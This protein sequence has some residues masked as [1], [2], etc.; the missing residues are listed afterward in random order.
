MTNAVP[1]AD[2]LRQAQDERKSEYYFDFAIVLGP[3]GLPD[4]TSV[5]RI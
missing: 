2:I 4:G 1:Q 5:N 3:P